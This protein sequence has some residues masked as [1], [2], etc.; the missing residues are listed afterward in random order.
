M[1]VQFTGIAST[2]RMTE[3]TEEKLL[4][5]VSCEVT[6]K[7]QKSATDIFRI[8]QIILKCKYM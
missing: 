8:W 5:G 1:Q 3:N 4:V 7:L 2:A 6:E